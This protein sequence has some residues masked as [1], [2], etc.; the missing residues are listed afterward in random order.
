MGMSERVGQDAYLADFA[1][2][3]DLWQYLRPSWIGGLA[4]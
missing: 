2:F 3:F 4:K 1:R